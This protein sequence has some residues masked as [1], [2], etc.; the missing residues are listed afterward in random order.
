MNY[1]K[2]IKGINVFTGLVHKIG[3]QKAEN[4][5][6]RLSNRS[7]K[8]GTFL[9]RILNGQDLSTISVLE[10]IDCIVNTK[11]PQIF[12][13]SSVSGDG[14][15]WNLTE[16]SIL[17]DISIS[18]PVSV[19][20]NAL[21]SFP[22]VHNEPFEATLIYTP[23]ALLENGKGKVPVDWDDVVIE[24]QIDYDAYFSLY[25]RR[26]LPCFLH[27]NHIASLKGKKALITIPGL[28]C[29][30]FAGKFRGQL[31]VLLK[32]T[33]SDLIKK[34]VSILPSIRAVYYDPFDEC[35]N[36]RME[37][38][39]ISFLIRPLMK[40][41]DRKAQLCKPEKYEDRTDNYTDCDLFSFV[42]WDHVSW[43]GNDF[44][45]GS[46]M[47]DDGVKAA[48]TNSMYIMTGFE[49][50][51]CHQSNAYKPNG[52]YNTWAEVV[53]KNK[54]KIN[55]KNNLTVFSPPQQE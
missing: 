53:L 3:F 9:G 19:Y 28:G 21:H 33:L 18:V 49:G 35:E 20:D 42:A 50:S 43:P 48:A 31:G 1:C 54:I 11:R 2:G 38:G 40:G 16:L 39:G 14:S 7:E 8:P 32:H 29:G 26:L 30:Q 13:E 15:D 46:R 10:F 55:L 23:G 44:Y 27:A 12:A 6:D 4:Y 25:E 24:N 34:Y 47:T 37:I 22:D 5:L 52:E 51:Y 41:N 45:I 36:E 17:G